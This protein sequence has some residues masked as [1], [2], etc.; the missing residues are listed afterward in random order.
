[1]AGISKFEA[2]KTPLDFSHVHDEHETEHT[3]ACGVVT[4]EKRLR[5]RQSQYSNHGKSTA[6]CQAY[7]CKG[8]ITSVALHLLSCRM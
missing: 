7:E 1:M 3:I 6:Y 5:L 2:D 4:I 8:P